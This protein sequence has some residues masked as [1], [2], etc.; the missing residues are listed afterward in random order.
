MRQST[1][2]TMAVLIMLGLLLPGA[3]IMCEA[4][5]AS[6]SS[7]IGRVTVSGTNILVDGEMPDERF[8]GVVDTTALQ[9]AIMAYING[10]AGVRG[11]TS[12]FN[13][14]DT[15]DYDR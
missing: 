9:F 11:W 4:P 1:N 13:T 6:A 5:A 15:N 7:P 3:L 10:D 8:F 12:V 2:R 14:P